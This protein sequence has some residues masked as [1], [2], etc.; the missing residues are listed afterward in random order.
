MLCWGKGKEEEKEEEGVLRVEEDLPSTV[1]NPY[2]L[3]T[4]VT[5]SSSAMTH[6]YYYLLIDLP[7]EHHERSPGT[8]APD[9]LPST[10][11]IPF[12]PSH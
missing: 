9:Q 7:I 11:I 5:P 6:S 8:L 4:L 12:D 10:Q 2:Y 3:T 1:C